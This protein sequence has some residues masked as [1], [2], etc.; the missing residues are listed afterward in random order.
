MFAELISKHSL[1]YAKSFVLQLTPYKR[2]KNRKSRSV[3]LQCIGFI[4]TIENNFFFCLRYVDIYRRFNLH[5]SKSELISKDCII[6][7]VLHISESQK[8]ISDVLNTKVILRYD[9]Y[10]IC[11]QCK[12]K[13]SSPVK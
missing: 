13:G 7:I 9:I 2:Q 11:R 6:Y 1:R 8:C 3:S 10:H 5:F 12:V 4:V